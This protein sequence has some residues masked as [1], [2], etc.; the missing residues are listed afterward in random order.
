MRT[1]FPDLGNGW[2][3][4]V[5]I[6]Y[7]VRCPLD[8]RFTQ[9]MGGVKVHVRTPFPYLGNRWAHWVQIWYVV[10]YP[11]AMRFTQLIGGVQVHVRTCASFFIYPERLK[12]WVGTEVRCLISDPLAMHS[13][14]LMNSLHRPA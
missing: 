10:R 6:W 12:D 11:L 14:L 8:K 7:V 4:W 2:A 9:L 13:C 3:N 1:P 5:Q